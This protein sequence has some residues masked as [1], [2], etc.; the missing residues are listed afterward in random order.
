MT[1]QAL[2]LSGIYPP[3][4]TP[5]ET[6][7]EVHYDALADNIARWNQHPLAG[8]VVLGS[9]G[10]V[11]YLSWEEKLRVLEA[12]RR[13]TPANKLVIA[14][15]RLE[16]TRETVAFTLEAALTGADAAL[17]LTP[18]YFDGKMTSESL[19]QHFCLTVDGD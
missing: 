18:H 16:S 3:I 5:F 6:S 15:T 4:T 11:S 13:S 9:N 7:G 19:Y 12:V 14:G 17:V 10:E 1:G 2:S 8:Y